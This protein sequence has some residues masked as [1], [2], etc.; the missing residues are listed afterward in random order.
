MSGGQPIAQRCHHPKSCNADH[1]RQ[2]Q[3][4]YVDRNMSLSPLDLLARI[5]FA[6]YAGL[7]AL[8]ALGV[9]RGGRGRLIA[10]LPLAVC[11]GRSDQFDHRLVQSV[12]GAIITPFQEVVVHG[13]PG[14]QI[15]GKPV[16]L[17]SRAGLKEVV[18]RTSHKQTF[19]GLPGSAGGHITF[20]RGPITARC[21]PV[22][23]DL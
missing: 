11:I 5:V 10:K 12:Q 23:S 16:A 13:A 18:L 9:D 20:R 4:K 19:R 15:V 17:T 8:D 2:Q 1:D 7:S 3:S 6:I 21:S 14:K 22:R